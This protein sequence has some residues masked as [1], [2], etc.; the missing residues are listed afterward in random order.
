MI[1]DRISGRLAGAVIC[2]LLLAASCGPVG[3]EAI[4][5]ELEFEP[6]EQMPVGELEL[7][8][9]EAAEPEV[10]KPEVEEAIEPEIEPEKEVS[11]AVVPEPVTLAL[12]F[13]PEDST[14]Y[15]VITETQQNV[16]W[17]GSVP[18][19]PIFQ[20]G[21]NHNRIEMVFNQQ[22]HDI[23]DE[24]NAIVRITIEELKYL[25]MVKNNLELDFDNSK[26]KNP[27][28]PLALLVGQGYTLRVAPTG[29]VAEVFELTEARTAV[30]R[31]SSIPK[32]ALALIREGVITERHGLL[33][34]PVTENNQLRTGDNW[35]SIKTFYF[36]LMG[37]KSYEKIST[38]KEIK[39]IDGRRIA[40]VEMNAIPT[41]ELEERFLRM[42]IPNDFSGMFE[43]SGTYTGQL[44][45][46]LTA[47]KVEKYVEEMKSE[48]VAAEVS[49][50]GEEGKGPAALKMSVTH[51][52]SLEKID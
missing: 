44:K 29:K 26:E 15:R 34:L 18:D 32:R 2:L 50:G 28:N 39:D 17:E 48:W 30:R 3:E 36:G 12:K 43:S 45:L 25:S 21:R 4:R 52:Y 10:D 40:I 8:A 49:G 20:G 1:S 38:V 37:L 5:P 22:I 51:F 11:E 16:E 13:T 31:G 35:S 9:E 6:E 14:T 23:D 33:A 47:G 7:P 19:K 24:G 41:S 46:D 27:N 42:E